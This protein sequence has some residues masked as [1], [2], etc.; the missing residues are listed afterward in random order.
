MSTK[1]KQLKKLNLGCGEDYKEGYINIDLDPKVKADKH[2][3]FMKSLP[4][5]SNSIDEVFTKN[6]FEHVPNPLNFL[7]EIRRVLK[8]GGRAVIITSN[9]S[10]ILY[11]WPRKKAYHD[12]YNLGKTMNDQH[13]FLFQKGHLIAFTKKAGLKLRR[14]DYYISNTNPGKD[15]YAQKLLGAILS[16]KFGYSDY[17]WV[18]EK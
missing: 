6:L 5:K 3:N 17:F 10:Y 12:S 8:K 9:A 7:L 13:Y 16:K 15:R 1:N 2:I 18:V 4:F 11:H 14:L